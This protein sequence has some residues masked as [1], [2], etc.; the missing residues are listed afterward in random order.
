MGPDTSYIVT[1]IR[2]CK[3]KKTRRTIDFV[4][5]AVCI[6][7]SSS[8]YATLHSHPSQSESSN[9]LFCCIAKWDCH[10]PQW[11]PSTSSGRLSSWLLH[12][13]L[14]SAF[15]V[16]CKFLLVQCGLSRCFLLHHWEDLACTCGGLQGLWHGHVRDDTVRLAICWWGVQDGNGNRV[17]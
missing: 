13:P 4:K 17:K 11:Y 3:K 5:G 12:R 2:C 7:F 15:L 14:P 10:Q 1:D 16:A 6:R 9:W 8:S